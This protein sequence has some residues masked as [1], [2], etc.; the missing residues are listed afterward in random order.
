VGSG[1]K[2]SIKMLP[3]ITLSLLSI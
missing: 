3:Y 2:T 1:H